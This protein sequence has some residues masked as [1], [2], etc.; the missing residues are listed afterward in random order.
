MAMS[1]ARS[2]NSWVRGHEVGL[3]VHLDECADPSAAMDVGLD[4]PLRG[5]AVGLLLSTVEPALPQDR[6]GLVHVALGLFERALGIHDASPRA[7]PQLLDH[8][9]GDLHRSSSWMYV[10][11]GVR[12]K[13]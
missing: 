8:L 7:L 10:A 5:D 12:R 1:W 6:G 4:Q 3:A 13:T 9:S 11:S 2:W